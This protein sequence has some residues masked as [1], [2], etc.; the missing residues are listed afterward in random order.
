VGWVLGHKNILGNEIADTLVKRVQKSQDF[1]SYSTITH[2]K[3]GAKRERKL[4][5]ELDRANN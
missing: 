4:L 5:Q 3:R 2:V 1:T